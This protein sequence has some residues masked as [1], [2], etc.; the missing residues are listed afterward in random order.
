[1]FGTI[2]RHQKWLWVVI[3]GLTIISFVIFGPTNTRLGDAFNRSRASGFGR[4]NGHPIT[5]E[6]YRAAEAEAHLSYFLQR[7]KWPDKDPDAVM[8]GFNSARETYFRLFWIEKEKTLGIQVSPQAVADLGRQVLAQRITA[9]DF[10]TRV[11]Q[12]V[13]LNLGD[14]ENFLRHDLGRQQLIAVAGLGA[15]S[16]VTPQEAGEMYRKEHQDLSTAAAFFSV[17]NF[18]AGVAASPEALAGYYKSNQDNYFIPKRVQVDYAEYD[19]ANYLEAAQAR[20]TNMDATVDG[21]YQRLGTNSALLGKT[22]AEIKASL[23]TNIL[24]SAALR[25]ARAAAGKLADDLY[26]AAQKTTAVFE[27][28]AKSNG[29]TV[30]TTSPFLEEDGPK[31]LDTTADFARAAFRL[32]T[33]EPFSGAIVGTNGVF[34]LGLRA[35]VPGEIPPLASVA[36]KVAVDYRLSVALAA[37]RRAGEQFDAGVTNAVLD[38]KAFVKAAEAAKGR[39][40]MLPP[41]SLSTQE[42][43]EAIKDRVG[44]DMLKQVA[45]TTM[46]G[47][48][49]R[50]VP[51]EDGGFVVYVTARSPVDEAKLK[52]ELP[53]FLAYL[54]QVRESE[55]MNAWF[56]R[57]IRQDPDLMQWLTQA[58]ENNPQL[59]GA[60]PR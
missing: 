42:A 44:L 32:T 22:T 38:A 14:F 51:T 34:V 31:G 2:R 11:L 45:F 10:E 41:F 21:Y 28:L 9:E 20:F 39:A 25:D 54:R 50:F 29:M 33:N 46:V 8:N 57:E 17:S 26:N 49:S 7:G 53:D 58:M 23:R 12:P 55:A 48:T 56:N 37:A 4:I 6:E 60:A 24:Q 19:A 47:K 35:V 52:K 16:L 30:H 15:S 3:A 43:P 5:G 27:Q 13:G 18:L 1:M 40:E 36:D 59:R